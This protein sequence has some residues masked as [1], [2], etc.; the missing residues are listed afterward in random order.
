LSDSEIDATLGIYRDRAHAHDGV[1]ES[2]GK[3][4]QEYLREL[5]GRYIYNSDTAA[6]VS[7]YFA[8]VVTAGCVLGMGVL[9]GE[10]MCNAFSILI[11][12]C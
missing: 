7:M 2:L 11:L 4:E 6:P 5:K 10:F 1:D 3:A 8:C 9:R 12:V